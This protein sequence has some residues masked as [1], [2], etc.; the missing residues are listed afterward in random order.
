MPLRHD[1]VLARVRAGHRQRRDYATCR[2]LTSTLG[3]EREDIIHSSPYK[4]P[5]Q[6][7]KDIC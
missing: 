5:S 6:R 3:P 2:Q 4:I 1:W 7:P